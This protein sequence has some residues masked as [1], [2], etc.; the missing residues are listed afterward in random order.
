M[1]MG[2]TPCV[3]KHLRSQVISHFFRLALR[4]SHASRRPP[5]SRLSEATLCELRCKPSPEFCSPPNVRD[6]SNPFASPSPQGSFFPGCI[7]RPSIE[8]RSSIGNSTHSKR[9]GAN[10]GKPGNHA[11]YFAIHNPRVRAV[12][13]SKLGYH[14][15]M[16]MYGTSSGLVAPGVL[17]SQSL[18]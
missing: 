10:F 1:A 5:A 15:C 8:H 12:V 16:V 13:L 7:R 17:V 3:G 11:F 4:D 9:C 2:R 6:H 14:E 18:F